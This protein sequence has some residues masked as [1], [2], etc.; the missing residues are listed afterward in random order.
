M[1]ECLICRH[2]V[3][4]FL[5]FGRMP[6][7]NAFLTEEEFGR[8][9][10]F[11]LKVGFC[12]RCTAVQLLELVDRERMFHENYAFF[13]STS[14]RMAD[15]F[16][17]FAGEVMKTLKGPDPFVVEIGSNDGIMLRHFASSGVR[18]LGVEPSANVAWEAQK[19]GVNTLCRFFDASVAAE[20]V[21]LH[22]KADAVLGANV[23][24]HIPYLSSVFQ[25][26]KT[27]LKPEGLFIFEDPYLGAIME[28][29]AY[30]QIY[31]EHAFYFSLSAVSAAIAPYDL[32]VIDVK[33]QDVHG[34]SLRY[35]IGHRGVHPVGRAVEET[36]FAEEQAG[37]GRLETYHEFR[38]RVERSRDDLI[39]LLEDLKGKGR[40]IA[41]YAATSKSATVINYC[42][43]T[44]RHLDYISDTTPIKQGKFSP[45]A[46]I[47]VLSPS[48]FHEDPPDYAVLFG[49]NH[50]EEI[51]EKEREFTARGG[52][53]ILYVPEVHVL[54]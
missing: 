36:R 7:A 32:E 25:G 10:F 40:C 49:W 14:L 18:H 45:G 28:K 21:A 16:A 37:L 1:K 52:K 5:S 35:L 24:C 44:R 8:E 46:H 12:P 23:M 15:H 29:T 17:A 3:Q 48:R 33:R 38:R 50:K 53:W 42:G 2:E 13:S 4:P 30:D 47:P 43:I 27:L 20:I 34:G 31:D 51:M 26:V 9:Y 19:R 54:P 39:N 22:G 6:V 11:E 41:G